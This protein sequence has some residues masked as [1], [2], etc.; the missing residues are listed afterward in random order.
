MTK[1]LVD[2]W[3]LVGHSEIEKCTIRGGRDGDTKNIRY[4]RDRFTSEGQR[5]CF[6]TEG[7]ISLCD[8]NVERLGDLGQ[9]E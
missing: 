7:N 4:A 6:V 3:K 9:A 2:K 5:C 1:G 8:R